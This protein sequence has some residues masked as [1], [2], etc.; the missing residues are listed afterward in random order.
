MIGKMNTSPN[1]N[2]TVSG[3]VEIEV[4]FVSKFDPLMSS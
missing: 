3:D 1:V 4:Q 2:D